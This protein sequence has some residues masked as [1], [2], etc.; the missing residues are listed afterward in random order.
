MIDD[1]PRVQELRRRVQADPASIA[2]AQLAEECRRAGS[3]EEAVSIARAGLVHHPDYLLA[4]VTLGRALVELSRYDEAE[5]ELA[6][7]LGANPENLSAIRAMAEVFQ[8][9]GQMK[10]ALDYYRRALSLARYDPDLESAVERIEHV[11]E[12]R[13]PKPAPSNEPVK[14][15]DLFDFDTLLQQLGGRTAETV[16]T[17]PEV[18]EVPEVRVPSALEQVQVPADDADPFSRLEQQLR[19]SEAQSA[20]A[21]RAAAEEARLEEEREGARLEA[22]LQ[23]AMRQEAARRDAARAK[24]ERIEA[25]R[26]EAARLEIERTEAQRREAA[27][28]EAERIE[29]ARLEAE[30]ADAARQEAQRAEAARREAERLEAERLFAERLFAERLEAERVERERREAERLEAARLEALRIETERIEAERVAAERR[31][32]LILSELEQWLVAI[33]SDRTHQAL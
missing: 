3:N 16:P 14:V 2:F 10:E 5:Q 28:L 31:E 27:R 25:E 30:R 9:R 6:R 12:P 33:E 7:V 32:Q 26:I 21:T 18:P 1:N 17:V 20:A 23:E 15:E 24:A 11:V 29:A 13:P 4:R 8:Q 22:E 19:D